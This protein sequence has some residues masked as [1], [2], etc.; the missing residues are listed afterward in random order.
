MGTPA[1]SQFD[2][3]FTGAHHPTRIIE[4]GSILLM[5]EILDASDHLG[6]IS[7][8]QAQAELSKGLIRGS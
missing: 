1:G 7:G 5:R 6:C 2:A 3:A 8:L 4:T